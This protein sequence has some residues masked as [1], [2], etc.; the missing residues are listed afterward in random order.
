MKKVMISGYYGFD[1]IGDDA[2]LESIILSFKKYRNDIEFVVLS[3]NPEKTSNHLNVKAINRNNL[4]LIIKELL[5]TNL[6]ISGGGGLFQDVTSHSNII[7]YGSLIKIAQILGVKT[8]I[9]AQGIGP[10]N[11]NISRK[12]LSNLFN[13]TNLITIR[14]ENSKN[15]LIKMG[16]KK[17]INI[18]ADPVLTLDKGNFNLNDII[19]NK[20]KKIIGVAI[21][22]WKDWYERQFKS[23]S[24]IL[25]Q[26]AKKYN[27]QILIIP[28]QISSDLWLS[29]ELYSYLNSRTY[30]NVEINLL[31]KA[32]TPRE[33]MSLI[34]NLDFVIGMRLHALIMAASNYINSLGIVYDPKVK[35]FC[36]LVGYPYIESIKNL[37]N[38]KQ[39]YEIIEKSIIRKDINKSE[40]INNVNKLK[41]LALKNTELALSL[42]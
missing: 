13:K 20:E 32:L 29:N 24:S 18:T 1:N 19:L 11:N 34:S 40:F 26:I 33:M 9:Y 28:F 16:V 6:F 31:N 36:D 27:Y 25:Y 8:M 42:I 12:I 7:Y 21:R 14:E 23:F 2:I 37:D 39:T 22:P 15:D 10:L 30:G 4:F 41:E 5:N 3:S 35:F 17:I 38:I